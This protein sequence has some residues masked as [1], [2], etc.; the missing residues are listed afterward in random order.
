MFKANGRISVKRRGV[1]E[2]I[3]TDSGVSKVKVDGSFF[4][5]SDPSLLS[6]CEVGKEINVEGYYSLGKLHA[7]FIG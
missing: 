2:E 3:K 6:K 1:I 5:V 7:N 4:I